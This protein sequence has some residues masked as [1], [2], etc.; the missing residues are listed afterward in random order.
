VIPNAVTI[1]G[2]AFDAE[3]KKPVSSFRVTPGILRS[4]NMPE[5]GEWYKSLAVDGTNGIF[6]LTFSGKNRTVILMAEADGYLPVRSGQLK[7]G[8]TNY[9]FQFHKGSGPNGIVRRLD[10][11]PVAGATVIYLAGQEQ[12]GLDGKGGLETYMQAGENIL[13]DATGQF[14]FAPQLGTGKIFAANSNGFGRIIPEA[15]QKSGVVILQP[16]ARVHGRL[17][18]DG[19]PVAGENVDLS[20]GGSFSHDWPLLNLHGAV[21]DKDGRFTIDF[22]PPGSMSISTRKHLDSDHSG[23]TNQQQRDFTAKPGEDI[24]LGDVVKNDSER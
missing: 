14:S 18:K 11:Q 20:W 16:W 23:W 10:G 12:G 2:H 22:V 3:T 21:T 19:K 6:A 7:A 4:P 5:S 24:D 15:L 13:T 8:Q 9:D 17:V 1:D